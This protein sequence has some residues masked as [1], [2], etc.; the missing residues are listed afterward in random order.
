MVKKEKMFLE[1]L[2]K[3]F[4]EDPTKKTTTYYHFGGWKQSKRKQ[5]FYRASQKIEKERG[6]PMY[7]PDTSLRWCTCR[8]KTSYAL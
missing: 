1:E 5:E 3:K 4:K 6:I 7:S 2:E 8:S